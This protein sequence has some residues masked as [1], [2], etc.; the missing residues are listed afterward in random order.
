MPEYNVNYTE[1]CEY[2]FTIIAKDEEEAEMMAEE[3]VSS[4]ELPEPKCQ[5]GLEIIKD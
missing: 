3:R 1:D 5:G 4:G 2:R